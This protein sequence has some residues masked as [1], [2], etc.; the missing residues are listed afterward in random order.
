MV[1]V[2]MSCLAILSSPHVG[3]SCLDGS[4]ASMA[5]APLT[6]LAGRAWHRSLGSPGQV[7][8]GGGE[9]LSALGRQRHISLIFL[10]FLNLRFVHCKIKRV[11]FG[12]AQRKAEV[13]VTLC[14]EPCPSVCGSC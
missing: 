11:P 6:S 9:A 1:W 12:R 8:V 4:P 2:G 7:A 13:P 10:F 3:R 5:S 14:R